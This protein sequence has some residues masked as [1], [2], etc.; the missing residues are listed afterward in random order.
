[1]TRNSMSTKDVRARASREHM[2]DPEGFR[3]SLRG[4]VPVIAEPVVQDRK[5]TRLNSSHS[6]ISYAVFCL[7]TKTTSTLEP[8]YVL[9]ALGVG[10]D[11]AHTSIRFGIGR[12]NTQQECAYTLK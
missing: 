4:A 7:T 9:K 12:F 1:M 8:S 10:E 5:S 11:L 2:S 3:T 6:Q